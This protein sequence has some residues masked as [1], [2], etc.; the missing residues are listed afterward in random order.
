VTIAAQDDI[1]RFLQSGSALNPDSSKEMPTN[2]LYRRG[3]VDTDGNFVAYGGTFTSEIQ[4][5]SWWVDYSNFFDDVGTLGGGNVTLVAGNDVK[6]VNASA[7]TNA[8]MTKQTATGDKLAADQTLYELGGGDLLVQA[9]RDINGGVYYTE[10]GDATLRAG[11][12]VTSNSTRA[13]TADATIGSTS[14]NLLPT[15][16]FLGKGSVDVVAGRNLWLGPVANPFLC[17]Q[18]VN[19]R[20]YET[21]YFS[22]FDATDSVSVSSL[23]GTVTLQVQSAD[24]DAG[25]ASLYN[26]YAK[27]LDANTQSSTAGV[28]QPW[29]NLSWHEAAQQLQEE[30]TSKVMSLFPG[31]LHATTFAGDIDLVGSLTLSPAAHGTVDLL[32]AGNLNGVRPEALSGVDYLWASAAINLSDASAL[33]GIID[34]L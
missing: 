19:N 25:G 29:L 2:W 5:T 33:P 1:A 20:I 24:S 28:D 6:N 15:T 21:S 8:R 3:S 17:Y 7:P 13:V 31:T 10:R 26:W 16:L 18:G 32:A 11:R 22:T 12:D 34:P 4:S 14:P 9:G 30:N 27:V 23:G